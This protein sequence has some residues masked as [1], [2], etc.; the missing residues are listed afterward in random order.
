MNHSSVGE[1]NDDFALKLPS[2]ILR[3]VGISRGSRVT[4]LLYPNSE[5]SSP[6]T[7][8][9]TKFDVMISVIP[10]VFWPVTARYTIKT[11]HK[12]GA[13]EEISKVIKRLNGNILVAEAS[14]CG[15][16][17]D[18]WNLA[19]GFEDIDT[20]SFVQTECVGRGFYRETMERSLKIKES[21]MN[22]CGSSLFSVDDG[23]SN[24]GVAQSNYLHD[25]PVTCFVNT[26][27]TYF[28][29]L[30]RSKKFTDGSIHTSYFE[31]NAVGENTLRSV[32]DGLKTAIHSYISGRHDGEYRLDDFYKS[33]VYASMDTKSMNIR[34]AILPRQDVKHFFCAQL[35]WEIYRYSK[36]ISSVGLINFI[37]GYFAGNGWNI[38]R[39]NSKDTL[40]PKKKE[41][42]RINFIL[43]SKDEMPEVDDESFSRSQLKKLKAIAPRHLGVEKFEFSSLVSMYY[44]TKNVKKDKKVSFVI[45]CHN[46]LYD[47]GVDFVQRLNG[48]GYD[49]ERL[50]K[51]TGGENSFS[52]I[53]EKIRASKILFVLVDAELNTLIRKERDGITTDSKLIGKWSL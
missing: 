47:D 44:K 16:R 11:A 4:A 5:G 40:Y 32:D 36:N 46:G 6:T 33:L 23:A 9:E 42:G 34:A 52:V 45:S 8:R 51:L 53:I 10:Y 14:R 29:N 24:Y 1:L 49:A 31:M 19:V 41:L 48:L 38:W 12:P 15:H 43:E 25:E 37:T 22:E 2:D 28:W 7:F 26:T 13:F 21:I 20:D 18:T 17:Y 35:D 50:W 3:P 30:T 39:I 27:L